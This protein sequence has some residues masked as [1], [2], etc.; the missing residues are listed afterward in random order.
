MRFCFLIKQGLD[1]F[2]CEKQFGIDKLNVD[3]EY[4]FQVVRLD[5]QC[6]KQG[7]IGTKIPS[8]FKLGQHL[9]LGKVY[10]FLLPARQSTHRDVKGALVNGHATNE[11][12][13]YL[14][15]HP[16]FLLERR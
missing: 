3:P 13:Q 12:G 15:N 6:L 11:Q 7:L 1:T 10:T 5:P 4:I 14:S 8:F 16:F 9:L 2:G